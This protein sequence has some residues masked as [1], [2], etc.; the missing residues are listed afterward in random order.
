MKIRL[1][2]LGE[3]RALPSHCSHPGGYHFTS[4]AASRLKQEPLSFPWSLMRVHSSSLVNGS[5]TIPCLAPKTCRCSHSC[6]MELLLH[7]QSCSTAYQHTAQCQVPSLGTAAIQRKLG[8]FTVNSLCALA[9]MTHS[10]LHLAWS[11]QTILVTQSRAQSEA[12][13]HFL[14][15][16]IYDFQSTTLV[17]SLQWKERKITLPAAKITL[18]LITFSVLYLRPIL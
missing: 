17:T 5:P 15:P 6:D 4:H 18:L 9:K 1:P 14:L 2:H 8:K 12:C 13:R 3:G 7:L 10:S 11:P 16:F